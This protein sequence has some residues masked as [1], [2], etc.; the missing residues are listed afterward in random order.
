MARLRPKHFKFLLAFNVALVVVVKLV[1]P[2][3]FAWAI[4]VALILTILDVVII[5]LAQD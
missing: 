2:E 1:R 4:G 3:W 5:A